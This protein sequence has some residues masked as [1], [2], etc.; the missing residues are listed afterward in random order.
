MQKEFLQYVSIMELDNED[1]KSCD[2]IMN[3]HLSAWGFWEKA[4]FQIFINLLFRSKKSR[5]WRTF[6]VIPE[7]DHEL[8]VWT[9]R[10][11]LFEQLN[12]LDNTLADIYK[13]LDATSRNKPQIHTVLQQVKVCKNSTYLVKY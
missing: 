9:D 1:S 8:T 2:N 13:H 5:G 7:L 6:L 10:R 12:Q 3:K 11:P 4:Q